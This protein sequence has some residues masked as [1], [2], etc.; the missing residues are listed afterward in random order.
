MFRCWMT[1]SSTGPPEGGVPKSVSE[2]PELHRCHPLLLNA[3]GRAFATQRI[4]VQ[5]TLVHHLATARP[6]TWSA[7][8]LV[9][10]PDS[11]EWT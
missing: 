9:V 7:A 2:S 11:A 3:P 1:A 6:G 8:A 10:T 4:R 5:G